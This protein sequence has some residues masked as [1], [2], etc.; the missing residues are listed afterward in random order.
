MAELAIDVWKK[1][2]PMWDLVQMM[3]ATDFD[4]FRNYV[5]LNKI[6][7]AKMIHPDTNQ[8]LISYAVTRPGEK[9]AYRLLQ[10]HFIFLRCV[11]SLRFIFEIQLNMSDRSVDFQFHFSFIKK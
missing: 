10:V 5:T 2:Q 11:E 8:N 3:L 9:S 6:N 4:E 7:V 1:N